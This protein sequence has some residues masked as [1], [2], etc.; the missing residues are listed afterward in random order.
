MQ[1]N[2]KENILAQGWPRESTSDWQIPPEKGSAMLKAFH[3]WRHHGMLL[4]TF[5]QCQSY[6]QHGNEIKKKL[7]CFTTRVNSSDIGV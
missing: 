2:I 7:K 6:L 3:L 4:L 1:N 5:P